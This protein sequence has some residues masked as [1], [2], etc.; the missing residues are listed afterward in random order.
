MP[1]ERSNCLHR[2]TPERKSFRANECARD[3][4]RSETFQK[5]SAALMRFP[6]GQLANASPYQ[7][8]VSYRHPTAVGVDAFQH[9]ETEQ[10]GR[11]KGSHQTPLIP[12]ACCLSAVFDNYE[13][14]LLSDW[15]NCVHVTRLAVQMCRDN[16]P[17]TRSYALFDFFGIDIEGQWVDVD[18]D[19]L[20]SGT[21]SNLWY[22]PKG[23]CRK[24]YFA[25]RFKIQRTQDVI[26]RHA[27][28]R[29]RGGIGRSLIFC[30]VTFV[31]SNGGPVHSFAAAKSFY[32]RLLIA[33]HRANS[34]AC[35][36][37]NHA[38]SANTPLVIQD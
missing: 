4:S 19:R 34:I 15:E 11:A 32:H 30:K 9:L 1:K 37:T 6:R 12:R 33:R 23:Q 35:Y 28:V 10:R 13:I 8:I 14:V 22:D 27:T 31:I 29:G 18:K 16:G 21:K 2:E 5:F 20:E 3:E 38:T 26:K 24:N 17:R 25:A 7:G 36:R